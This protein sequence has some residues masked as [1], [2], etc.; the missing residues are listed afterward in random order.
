MMNTGSRHFIYGVEYPVNQAFE[1]ADSDEVM[2]LQRPRV[3][4]K[5]R[6][7]ASLL[8]RSATEARDVNKL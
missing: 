7:C 3:M 1:H 2:E 6:R 4:L 5:V 8:F